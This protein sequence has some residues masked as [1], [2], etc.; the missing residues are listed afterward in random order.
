MSLIL[1][2]TEALCASVFNRA[3][4]RDS[5]HKASGKVHLAV[6]LPESLLACL[7]AKPTRRRQ[8]EKTLALK[9]NKLKHLLSTFSAIILNTL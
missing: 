6:Y 7:F 2:I 3:V 9:N 1:L 5:W 8:K 4:S